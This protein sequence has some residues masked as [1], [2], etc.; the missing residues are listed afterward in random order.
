MI[1]ERGVTF[2]G[3]QKQRISIARAIIRNSPLLILDEATSSLDTKSEKLVQKALKGLMQGKTVLIIAHR[4]STVQ[5]ADKIIV[6]ERG[7]IIEEGDHATLIRKDGRYCELS[8]AQ[9]LVDN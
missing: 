7:K 6:L 4:L 2:S 8:K 5:N 3:G 9:F 1:G